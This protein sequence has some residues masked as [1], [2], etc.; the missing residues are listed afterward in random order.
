MSPGVVLIAAACAGWAI[1]NNLTRK[2]SNAN[3]AQIACAKGLVAG[4]VSVTIALCLHVAIP[5]LTIALSSMLI[6]FLGYGVSLTCFVLALRHIGAAR[7]GAYYSLAPF[8]GA[9]VSIAFLKEPVSLQFLAA[10]A[11]MGLGLWLHLSE[12]HEHEHFHEKLEHEHEHVHD[13]HHQHP[14]PEG[15]VVQPGVPHTHRHVHEELT[16]NHPHFPDMHHR[17]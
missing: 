1:D 2:V 8:A 13:E 16:H 17:H 3:P 10:G 12:V 6:G 5:P 7:T 9:I 14:H 11:L 4:V 15:M